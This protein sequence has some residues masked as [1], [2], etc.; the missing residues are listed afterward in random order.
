MVLILVV[1]PWWSTK[2][3]LGKNARKAAEEDQEMI[4]DIKI[5]S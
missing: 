3:S 2:P 1:D 4:A 5:I